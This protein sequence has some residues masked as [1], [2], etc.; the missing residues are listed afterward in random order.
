VLVTILDEV[1]TILVELAGVTD[2]QG[3]QREENLPEQ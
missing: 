3:G 1:V 2:L